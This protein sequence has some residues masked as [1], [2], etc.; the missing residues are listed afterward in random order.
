MDGPHTR[1]KPKRDTSN[2]VV[3]RPV[4]PGRVPRYG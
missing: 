3:A 2:D 1:P 4:S